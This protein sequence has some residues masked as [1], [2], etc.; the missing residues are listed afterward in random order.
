MSA[1]VLVIYGRPECHL[2][3]VAKAVAEPVARRLGITVEER[4]VEDSPEW[5]QRFGEQVPVG[6]LGPDKVFKYRVD[7][8]RL[9]AAIRSRI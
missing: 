6:F 4:N 7:P 2:C 5:E 3:D 8:G 1:L 9:E